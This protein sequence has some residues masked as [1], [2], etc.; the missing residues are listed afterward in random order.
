MQAG[1]V[2]RSGD[3]FLACPATGQMV[4]CPRIPDAAVHGA[5]RYHDRHEAEQDAARLRARGL[6]A[7]VVEIQLVPYRKD[8]R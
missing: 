7:E 4:A 1:F 2:V 8:A 5:H 6:E 3:G